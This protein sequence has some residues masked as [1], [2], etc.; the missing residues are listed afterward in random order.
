MGLRTAFPAAHAVQDSL[1]LCKYV[2][3]EEKL[4]SISSSVLNANQQTYQLC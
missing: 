3:L 2:R 4:H 1:L